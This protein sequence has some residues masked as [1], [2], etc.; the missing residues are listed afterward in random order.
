MKTIG[1]V[2]GRQIYY[3]DGTVKIYGTSILMVGLKNEKHA[4]E[5]CKANFR[6]FKEK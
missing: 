5:R 6:N 3:C 4:V 1:Q 2:D